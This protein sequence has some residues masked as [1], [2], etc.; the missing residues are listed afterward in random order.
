MQNYIGILWAAIV[1][2]R[3]AYIVQHREYTGAATTRVALVQTLP[4]FEILTWDPPKSLY[5]SID[6]L[7][8]GP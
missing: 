8:H 3:Y 2:F 6:S 4:T 5:Q 7:Q 1:N